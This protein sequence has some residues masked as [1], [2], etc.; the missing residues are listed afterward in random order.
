ML[1]YE[2][3]NIVYFV[4]SAATLEDTR[5]SLKS[6][7]AASLK[8][9]P[10][11]KASSPKDIQMDIISYAPLE[12]NETQK[13]AVI[14][15]EADAVDHGT[16]IVREKTVD[17]EEERFEQALKAI[18]EEVKDLKEKKP[19]KKKK[20]R[21]SGPAS[22]E[23]NHIVRDVTPA[24]PPFRTGRVKDEKAPKGLDNKEITES[25]SKGKKGKVKKESTKK[26]KTKKEKQLKKK[27]TFGKEIDDRKKE[28]ENIVTESNNVKIAPKVEEYKEEPD[29]E[30][31]NAYDKYDVPITI[32]PATRKSDSGAEEEESRAPAEETL[33][34]EKEDEGAITMVE[35]EHDKTLPDVTKGESFISSTGFETDEYAAL[36][37]NDNDEGGDHKKR[38]DD[39][40]QRRKMEAERRRLKVEQKR[41]EKEEAKR[42]QQEQAEREEKMKQEAELEMQRR[43]EEVK[44]RKRMEEEEKRRKEE[45]EKRRERKLE[46]EREREKREK[47]EMKRKMAAIAEKLRLEEEQR[48]EEERL[49]R[50]IEEELK[51]QEEEMLKAMEEHERIE[52]ERK[53]KEEEEERLR[54]EEERKRLERERRLIEE[55]EHRI[56]MQKLQEFHQML[57]ERA[58]FWEGMKN[59]KW[60]LEISQRLTRAFTFSYFDLLPAI[61]FEFTSLR[62]FTPKENKFGVLPTIHEE[63]K[64][65]KS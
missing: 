20:G 42:K 55:E 45:E 27:V 63:K 5:D 40:M 4:E 28:K 26:V 21:K 41:R 35:E 32:K 14:Q 12:S 65:D 44:N 54:Q 58:K 33:E 49:A 64:E 59:S 56:K 51:R 16:S 22:D 6:F 2:I 24:S 53:K 34:E 15:R 11:L 39:R 13:E 8:S 37:S 46:R 18:V 57:L 9:H 52:Y 23:K 25:K 29:E 38:M 47:E 43:M 48:R 1:P 7:P 62:P 50:E 17:T 31:P 30:K 19:S 3:Y 60:F 10:S 61:L 36:S